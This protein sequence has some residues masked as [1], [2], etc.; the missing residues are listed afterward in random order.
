MRTFSKEE[1][2]IMKDAVKEYDFLARYINNE[3]KNGAS[4]EQLLDY[5]ET[6]FDDDITNYDLGS[7]F[8][9]IDF[10]YGN[11]SC[12]IVQNDRIPTTLCRAIGIYNMNTQEYIFENINIDEVKK[13]IEESDK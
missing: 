2:D 7:N 13:I 8:K 12:S 9:Y 3:I 6:E 5:V 1:I 4:M 11:I 10:I